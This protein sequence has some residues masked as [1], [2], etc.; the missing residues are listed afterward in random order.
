MDG[1]DTYSQVASHELHSR[2][3]VNRYAHLGTQRL[4][5]LMAVADRV[6]AGVGVRGRDET[7]E[8]LDQDDGVVVDLGGDADWLEGAAL[9]V[10]RARAVSCYWGLCERTIRA[11]CDLWAVFRFISPASDDPPWL[12]Q[13]VVLMQMPV[14]P[15]LK[16]Q[17][18]WREKMALYGLTATAR[19]TEVVDRATRRDLANEFI[20]KKCF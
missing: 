11:C 15:V 4:A 5:A 14:W 6:F 2:G 18:T 20:L 3:L 1:W 10:G 12:A 7:L 17:E 13:L 19:A 9:D 8:S 16:V